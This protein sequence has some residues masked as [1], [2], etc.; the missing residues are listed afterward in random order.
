MLIIFRF[1]IITSFTV[2]PIT[3]FSQDTSPASVTTPP[4]LT[5]PVSEN[6]ASPPTAE[7]VTVS[8]PPGTETEPPAQ[9]T[10]RHNSAD[11][12]LT[13]E[14][15]SAASQETSP[16]TTTTA[17]LEAVSTAA[18]SR[19]E[20]EP[21]VDPPAK[22]KKKKKKRKKFRISARIHAAWE[23]THED[24]PDDPATDADEYKKQ[25]I[26][27]QFDIRQAR[28][29]LRWQPEK[30]LTAVI[31]LAGFQDNDFGVSLLRDAYIHV[32]P[33]QYLE[34]R[35]GL[36]K[37]PFSRL[38]LRSFGKLR[39][40]NRGELNDLVVEDLRYGERD[41]GL[42]FS[43]RILPDIK[44]DYEVGVFNGSGP[45]VSE[46]GNS[47]DVAARIQ[48]RPADWISVGTNASFKFFDD[49]ESDEDFAW[50]AG[51][52]SVFKIAEFRA[53]VE[54]IAAS[55]YNFEN[56]QYVVTD[57]QPLIFG[58]VTILSYKH[59]ISGG[60]TGLALEPVFKF[61]LLDPNHKVSDDQVFTYDAGFNSYIGKYLRLMIHGEFRRPAKN[62]AVQ[63]PKQE[64]LAVQ[65]CFD[66]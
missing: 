38:Q 35:A 61:E 65:F 63:F 48:V 49:E 53:H 31:Q 15:G 42:Q 19:T 27:S 1:A 24:T 11:V 25:D 14:A 7:A 22:A 23:M 3:A 39:V 62:S 58:L 2:F 46:R 55:D 45:D 52:D 41:L 34:I 54:G 20:I 18:Q 57:T 8:E 16:Q 64:I 51:V 29:K 66:I 17:P 21:P 43:G 40:L 4:E 44:L 50:A 9:P 59:R 28:F 10:D 32:S 47:K 37:K 6:P 56:R 13:P 30:R 26:E 12:S 5:S 33:L 60:S 36:F